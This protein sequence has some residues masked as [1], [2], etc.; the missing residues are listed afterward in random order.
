MGS[1]SAMSSIDRVLEKHSH[2]LLSELRE[3]YPSK[4]IKQ[5]RLENQTYEVAVF[6]ELTDGTTL[7]LVSFDIDMLG[8]RFTDCDVGY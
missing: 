1:I 6:A 2:E 3:S 8:D 4:F 5:F 7:E